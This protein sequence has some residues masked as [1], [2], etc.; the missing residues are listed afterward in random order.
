MITSI[1]NSK[2]KELA[3]LHQ[4]KYRKLQKKYLVEGIHLIEEAKMAGVLLEAYSIEEKEGYE[5]ISIEVMKHLCMTD[6]VVKELGVCKMAEKK[7]LDNRILLLDAI[8]DP[9]NMGTLLRSAVAFGFSTVVLGN[10]CVDIYNDKVIRSSQGAIFKINILNEPLMEFLPRLSDYM[11]YSTDVENGKELEEIKDNGKTAII[12][13][14]E[15]NGI[16]ME[17]KEA[18]S[19]RIYIPMWNTESLNVAVAGSI[20]MYHFRKNK[21]K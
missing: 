6:T 9:G 20:I 10:G 8:Q 7:I 18:V 1:S 21:K 19:N 5:L 4:A 11:I 13:G 17:V 3:K 12:L 16:S 15:G 2:I 14:N